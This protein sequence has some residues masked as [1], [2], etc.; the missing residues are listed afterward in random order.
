MTDLQRRILKLNAN[1]KEFSP[2]NHLE[3]KR[4]IVKEKT[5][6]DFS[7]ILLLSLKQSNKQV[8]G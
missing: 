2:T 5:V 7:S 4:L 6:G 8:I 1:Q 3:D